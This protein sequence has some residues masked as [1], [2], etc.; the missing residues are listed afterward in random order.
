M[1]YSL[2]ETRARDAKALS[3]FLAGDTDTHP[4]GLSG[5]RWLIPSVNDKRNL[6]CG[7][8]SL[9]CS[10]WGRHAGYQDDGPDMKR[11]SRL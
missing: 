7:L 3:E 1:T 2:E 9:G 6:D 4:H 10:E 8:H 5:K 11:K